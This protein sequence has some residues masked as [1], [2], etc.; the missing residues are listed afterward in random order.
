MQDPQIGEELRKK[1]EALLEKKKTPTNSKFYAG[2]AHGFAIR[3]DESD[4]K[5]RQTQ[6]DS[7]AEMVALLKKYGG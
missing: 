3:G 7:F 4:P 2:A 1:I 5:Q 6:A